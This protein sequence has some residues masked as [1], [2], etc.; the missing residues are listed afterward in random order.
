MAKRNI[1]GQDYDDLFTLFGTSTGDTDLGTFSGITISDNPSV[2]TALQEIETA[3]EA[4]TEVSIAND[5]DNRVI[6]AVGDS[7]FSAESN[8]LFDG[9]TATITGKLA[10]TEAGVTYLSVENTSAA[11]SQASAYIFGGTSAGNSNIVWR[12]GS[13]LN[14]GTAASIGGAITNV[15][16]VG[17][18]G[19]VT[20]TDNAT[21]QTF[22]DTI[23]FGANTD[24]FSVSATNGTIAF[25]AYIMCNTAS[26]SVVKIYD[27]VRKENTAP[28]V[29]MTLNTGPDGTDDFTATFS[30][31]GANSMKLNVANDSA[32]INGDF[33]TTLE[34]AGNPES[35]TIT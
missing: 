8:F 4:I 11:N 18:T 32:S 35:Y 28:I 29:N 19:K 33:V 30:S 24:V 10:T 2:K 9:S 13:S 34:L 21:K 5:G 12:S 22:A 27:V 14:L 20:Y 25:R 16:T 17:N 15:F 3:L 26:F 31:T 6:T 1:L 7:T 23:N